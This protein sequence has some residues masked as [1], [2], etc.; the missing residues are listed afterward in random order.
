M[1]TQSNRHFDMHFQHWECKLL[2][3][4][5][6]YALS[7]C[8]IWI[9]S[10]ALYLTMLVQRPLRTERQGVRLYVI[11]GWCKFKSILAMFGKK[12]IIA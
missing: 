6:M 1:I 12:K 8:N 3:S 11:F 5:Y 9:L 4:I 7:A 2:F 10:E